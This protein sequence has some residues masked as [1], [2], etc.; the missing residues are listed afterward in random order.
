M[1]GLLAHF[2][3][4]SSTAEVFA[5]AALVELLAEFV[6]GFAFAGLFD[7]GIRSRFLGISLPFYVSAVSH[8]Y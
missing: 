2:A 7:V 4:K 6:G 5:S 8:A 3:D 1:Q